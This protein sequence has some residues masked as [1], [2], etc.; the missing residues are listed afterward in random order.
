MTPPGEP[1]GAAA[2]ASVVVPAYNVRRT[3]DLCLDALVGQTK[4]PDAIY[5]VD[6]G[7]TDGT[8]ERLIERAA[9]E[10]RLHVL[11]ETKRGQSAARNAAVRLI[12]EGTVAFTD[13]DCIPEPQWLAGLAA[14]HTR[15]NVAAVAGSIVGYEPRTLVERYLSITGFPLPGGTSVVRRYVPSLAFYTGNLS[16]RID[17]LRRFGGFDEG[18]PVSEDSDLCWRLMHAGEAVAY[19]PHVRV[20][21]FHHSTLR[22]MLRRLFEYG[23]SQPMLA[24]KY[25]P[26][27]V[28]ARFAR[29]T[30][31]LRAPVTVCLNLTSPEKVSLAL[32]VLSVASPW[33]LGLLGLYWVRLA[34]LL[35]RM[36]RERGVPVRSLAEL[37]VFT[38]LHLLDFCA[39]HAG[40]LIESPRYRAV[41]L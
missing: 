35:K 19:A 29:Y 2:R 14:E 23:A 16:V 13:A 7:S 18:M 39:T 22:A 10:P 26:G 36:A 11:R 20:A 9:R 21:H 8:Y 15:W 40:S 3:I 24:R 41:W 12:E 30:L 1:T 33:F 27:V 6:N 5:V 17:A 34:F 4:P 37:A 28:Y 25:F 31:T 32:L 38:G